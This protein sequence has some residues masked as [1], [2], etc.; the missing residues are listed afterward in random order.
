MKQLIFCLFILSAIFSFFL[1]LI[2]CTKSEKPLLFDFLTENGTVF[3]TSTV[4]ITFEV[5]DETIHVFEYL[6]DDTASG[7]TTRPTITFED[8]AAGEHHLCLFP[9]ETPAASKTL[10]FSV[11]LDGPSVQVNT[12]DREYA[13][14][15]SA[16]P[17]GRNALVYWTYDTYA[18]KTQ[19]FAIL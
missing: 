9:L 5:S 8:M 18:L 6:L 1:T 17:M 12:A 14:D 7:T 16:A 3:A 10:F 15:G 13:I 19:R 4:T 11:N 2:S